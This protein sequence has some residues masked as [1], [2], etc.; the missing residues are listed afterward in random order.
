MLYDVFISHAYEDK[1]DFVKPLADK[2]IEY[3]I[4]VWYDEYSLS[5]GDS[6]RRSIDKGLKESTYGI[7]VLS[8]NFFNKNWSQYE[9]DGL[10]QLQS[11][12]KSKRILPIWHN[13]TK[14][15]IINYSPTLADIIALSSNEDLENIVE[16]IIKVIKPQG[17]SLIIA[18]DTM[19]EYGAKPPVISDDWWLDVAISI[20]NYGPLDRWQFPIISCSDDALPIERGHYLAWH[21]M[22]QNWVEKADTIPITQITHPE[23]VLDFIEKSPGLKEKC[24]QYPHF[25]LSYVP[26]IGIK[27]F[28]GQFYHSI[29]NYYQVSIE[30]QQKLLYENSTLGSGLTT[31]KLPP[32]CEENLALRHPNFGNYKSSTIA[33][34]FTAGE[35]MGLMPRY[36]ATIDYIVWFLSENSNW[37]PNDIKTFLIDGYK[38]W[39]TWTWDCFNDS[40]SSYYEYEYQGKHKGALAL[41]IL[42]HEKK[43]FTYSSKVL[44]DIKNRFDFSKKVLNIN[45]NTNDLVDKF[46]EEKFVEYHIKRFYTETRKRR[47]KSTSL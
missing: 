28:E 9:L 45:D 40:G 42:N 11:I 13:I 47:K 18:R 32:A 25:L 2:L 5:V 21:A 41:A 35:V 44:E 46:I 26:Q 1:K 39:G 14:E 15:E 33:S 17:S 12:S 30:K 23:I 8:E 4:E 22:Q 38:K 31:N 36:Y 19:I 43:K 10:W 6:L 16:K 37:F 24:E 3:G 34:T 27:G 7:I 20:E 29:E